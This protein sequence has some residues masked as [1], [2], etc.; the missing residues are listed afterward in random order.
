MKHVICGNGIA[1]VSAAEAIRYLDPSAQITFISKEPHLPYSRPMIS[2]VLA[3]LARNSEIFIRNQNFYENLGAKVLSGDEAASIDLQTKTVFTKS[4]AQI[5]YDRLLIATGA[6]PRPIKAQGTDLAGIHFMRNRDQVAGLL[7]NI[8]TC[9]KALVL[10]GGLVGFKAAY[11]LMLRGIA[12]HMLIGS[13]HPLSMQLDETAGEIV[14]KKLLEKGLTVSLGAFVEAFSGE[15]GWVKTAH[16]KDGSSLDCDLVVIGKG[17]SPALDFARKSG[18]ETDLGLLVD[19]FLETNSPGV[20][21]A[22]DVAQAWDLVHRSTWVNAIWPVAAEQGRLAG[23]NM[24]GRKTAYAGGMGR[25][26]MRV[27]DLD[28]MTGGMVNPPTDPGFQVISRLG[29][30][31]TSYARLVLKENRLVGMA[32]V[33]DV[34]QGGVLLSL[35]KNQADLPMDPADLLEP[36]F[37]YGSLISTIRPLPRPVF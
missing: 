1:G 22:G 6:D 31:Q 29:Y 21:A 35:I 14:L 20:Y 5:S 18:L 37:N 7:Q 32:L 11:G 27:F 36:G 12:V 10:G 3:G 23:M 24:A 28:V 13:G 16:L 30:D 8:A 33:G 25:N 17:V 15:K 19:R 2:L 9:K 4:G 34:E 26:V